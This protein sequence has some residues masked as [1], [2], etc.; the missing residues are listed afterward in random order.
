VTQFTTRIQGPVAVVG[1]VHGQT[2]KL[3]AVLDKLRRLRDYD[4]R[5]I[6]FIGDFVDRG[7][8]P[9]GSIDL[10]LDLIKS[11]PRTTAICGNHEYAMCSSLGWIPT[12]DAAAWA[13]RWTDHYDADT[14]L[15]SYG[16]T[17]D[18]LSELAEKI[19]AAHRDFLL[20][21]P[22]CVEHPEYLFVHAGLDPLSPFAMQLRILQ[23]KDFTLNRPQ[24]LFSKSYVESDPPKDCPLT[25]VSGHVRVPNV[26][27]K[28][29]RI[30]LDTTG[31]DDGDL[32]C[33]LLPE[34][35]IVSSGAG[36]QSVAATIGEKPAKRWW[37]LF[38]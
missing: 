9:K 36:T 10:V 7:P 12:Q 13:A 1:D 28:P 19:P 15:D 35:T 16:F 4:E 25:V 24:W 5:W 32:S 14:T 27:V 6:V 2:D 29:K 30:L 8:D 31:G 37:Q 20:N 18:Q 17:K 23:K 26:V 3:Q 22:W 21:L 11:H 38:G 34:K 33:V